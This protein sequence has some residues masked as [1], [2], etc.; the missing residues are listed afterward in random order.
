[1][2]KIITI[3]ILLITLLPAGVVFSKNTA[4]N[5][6][7]PYPKGIP[8]KMT[9][10]NVSTILRWTPYMIENPLGSSSSGFNTQGPFRPLKGEQLPAYATLL[11]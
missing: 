8:S 9:P 4:S 3:I 6:V 10:F 7:L 2:N 5:D 1:M 11:P